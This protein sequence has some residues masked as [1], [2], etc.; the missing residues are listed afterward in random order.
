M[1]NYCQNFEFKIWVFLKN[2]N[3]ATVVLLLLKIST[4]CLVLLHFIS[5]FFFLLLTQT[6]SRDFIV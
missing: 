5:G 1:L 2:Y 4:L 6:S 3:Y